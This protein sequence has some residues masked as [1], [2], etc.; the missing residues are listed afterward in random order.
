[1]KIELPSE[2]TPSSRVDPSTMVIYSHPKV[3]KTTAV[4]MLPGCLTL[5]LQRGS[6]FVDILK[7]DILDHTDNINASR[8]SK[9]EPPL[10]PIAILLNVI[11]QL[12]AY[13]K[14]HGEYQ[15]RFIAVDTLSDLEEMCMPLAAELH[16]K[17]P[18]GKNWIGTDVT[19]L[20]KGLGYV[21]IREA[22]RQI[23]DR[24]ERVCECAIFLGH[25][26]D[27]LIE[28]Q[29]EEIEERGL[30]LTGL[31]STIV[32]SNVDTVGYMYRH[33]GKTVINFKASSNTMSESRS[34]HLSNKIIPILELDDNGELVAHWD[35]VFKSLNN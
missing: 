2:K 4:S 25:V 10:P 9:N 34:K 5:D 32:C 11:N 1:M 3:G 16:R 13:Y 30:K 35:K 33:E 20:P 31:L 14:E 27:K 8:A 23:L 21:Y 18:M 15:Y 19:T 6:K 26:R 29:G 28:I 12:E 24:I 17:T 7:V 22:V